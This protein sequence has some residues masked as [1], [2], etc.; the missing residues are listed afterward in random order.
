MYDPVGASLLAPTV[1]VRLDTGLKLSPPCKTQSPPFAFTLSTLRNVLGT[2]HQN[3]GPIII[4]PHE[5]IPMKRLLTRCLSILCGTA[6]L[7]TLF[8]AK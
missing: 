2:V 6:L 7:S 4:L 3:T 5:T 8:L 1:G